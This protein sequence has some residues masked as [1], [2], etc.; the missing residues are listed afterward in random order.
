MKLGLV[1][2]PI[3]ETLALRTFDCKR[4]TVAIVEAECGS[5][6]VT[7]IVFSKIPMQMFLA[8]VLINAAHATFEN[9]KVILS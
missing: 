2:P 6:I 3:R 7:K 5:V 8:A 1:R 9:R 4:R